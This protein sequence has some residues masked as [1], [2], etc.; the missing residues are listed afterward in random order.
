M[1]KIL[2][3]LGF[4]GFFGCD[5]GS[6]G[7]GDGSTGSGNCTFGEIGCGLV[8]EADS[9]GTVSLD[10]T[11][12]S[13]TYIISPYALGNTSTVE[14]GSDQQLVFNSSLSLSLSSQNKTGAQKISKEQNFRNRILLEK[15][16]YNR[17]SKDIE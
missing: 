16:I 15:A 1:K 11:G 9:S 13:G 10:L 14:G 6:S 12:Q 4:L 2:L 3:S 8:S 17:F 7:G 5:S